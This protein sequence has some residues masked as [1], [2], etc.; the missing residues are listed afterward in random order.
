MSVPGR[1]AASL[2]LLLLL[3]AVGVGL[4][5]SKSASTARAEAAA[6]NLPEPA[7]AVT[8]A[9]VEERTHQPTTTAVGTVLALRS[10]TVRNE[11]P[12][13]VRR[14]ALPAG[15]VVDADAV[16]VAL[17]VSVEEAELAA[18]EAQAALAETQLGR[19]ERITQRGAASVMEADRARAERDVA[20]AQIARLKA[21]IARRVIRAPFRGRVGISDVHVGQYLAAGTELTTLQ[22]VDDAVHVDFWVAQR[23][24]EGLAVGTRV[25]VTPSPG[26]PALEAAVA[27]VDARVDPETRTARVPGTLAGAPGV[28]PPGASVRVGVPAGPPR[29]V[30]AVPSGALRRGP[31]G[32]HVFVI[33]RDAQ[34]TTR[35]HVRPV[36]S[37]PLLGDEVL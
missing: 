21:V 20:L 1:I 31:A 18:Q 13:T 23:V 34:G 27:A 35:A 37:G 15:E 33:A 11:V 36:H 6:S 28:P 14:V 29:R 25:S 19:V 30:V 3:G 16:L 22:S 24:A 7:D 4:A 9:T 32:D 12:G 10:I 5:K 26:A 8:V 2:V 17:D